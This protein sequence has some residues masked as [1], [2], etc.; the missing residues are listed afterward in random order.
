[1]AKLST[2]ELS[3]QPEKHEPPERA[4][5]KKQENEQ[6]IWSIRSTHRTIIADPS[7]SRGIPKYSSFRGKMC[8]LSNKISGV[9]RQPMMQTNKILYGVSKRSSSRK[10]DSPAKTTRNACD[11]AK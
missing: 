7:C 1:M 10:P 3:K 4:R 9:E 5:K 11:R 8:N 2:R 6:C